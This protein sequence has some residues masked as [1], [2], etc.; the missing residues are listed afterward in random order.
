[1]RAISKAHA[2]EAEMQ[3]KTYFS[4]ISVALV[5]LNSNITLAGI[6]VQGGE[7]IRINHSLVLR[8]LSDKTVCDW[9]DGKTLSES[10]PEFKKVFQKL[11]EINWYFSLSLKKEIESL[12]ICLT[13]NLIKINTQDAAALTTIYG[14]ETI[15]VAIR[16]ENEVYIDK[17]LFDQMSSKSQA[18][19]L[20]HEGMHG[21]IPLDVERR[22]QKVRSMTKV[23]AKV[24]S[25]ALTS[26]KQFIKNIQNNDVFYSADLKEISPYRDEIEFALSD[27]NTQKEVLLKKTNLEDFFKK[28][29]SMNIT[30]TLY[31]DHQNIIDHT[32]LQNFTLEACKSE[33]TKLI[34]KILYQDNIAQ[35]NPALVCLSLENVFQNNVILQLVY[36]STALKNAFVKFYNKLSQ[37]EVMQENFRLKANTELELLSSNRETGLNK[38]TPVMQL[39]PVLVIEDLNPELKGFFQLLVLIF[40]GE[41]SE[42]LQ[43]QVFENEDFYKAFGIGKLNEQAKNAA[44]F[45]RE[46]S[47]ARAQIKVIHQAV[48]EVLLEFLEKEVS[49]ERALW[50]LN[51][52]HWD[53]LGIQKPQSIKKM[54][55]LK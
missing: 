48:F 50:F 53:E 21:F 9:T 26:Q 54:E 7:A 36:Q 15:Q 47:Y 38:K 39:Q 1:V 45:P 5:F 46:I 18:M 19:L 55:D 52:I 41:D 42:T 24:A 30:N 8:D 25:G 4:T 20:V 51:Q 14:D 32:T 37:K 3:I 13:S 27:S 31:L 17:I 34:E 35:F 43:E 44:H 29:H 23:I 10:I 16:L 6:R 2:Q 11:S 28:L 33:D 49:T 40:P 22:N 12:N